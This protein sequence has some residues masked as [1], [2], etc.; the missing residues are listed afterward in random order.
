MYVA[1]KNL[2][3]GLRAI[4]L[5]EED[6]LFDYDLSLYYSYLGKVFQGLDY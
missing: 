5:K 3:V 6:S 4:F 2:S 1:I